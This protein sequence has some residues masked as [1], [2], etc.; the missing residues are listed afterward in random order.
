MSKI[1]LTVFITGVTLLVLGIGCFLLGE[2]FPRLNSILAGAGGTLIGLALPQLS[3]IGKGAVAGIVLLASLSS[4][5]A[6]AQTYG[7]CFDDG[8]ICAGPAVALTVGQLNLST[9]KFGG[10]VSPGIGYGLVLHPDRWYAT[11]LAFYAA[12][13]VG[14]G[15]PNSLDPSLMLSFAN[16][17][18]IGFAVPISER[19]GGGLNREFVLRFGIGADVGKETPK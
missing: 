15:K 5:P 4:A 11:G 6:Q 7:G 19:E 18:R 14:G 17:L 10:G 3:K 13:S 1:D 16:Y 12:F 2:A 8:R 9:G